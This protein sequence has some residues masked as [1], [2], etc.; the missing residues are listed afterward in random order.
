MH[1]LSTYEQEKQQYLQEI[2]KTNT[3]IER[4]L[5]NQHLQLA[6]NIQI[7]KMR[8]ILEKN[9]KFKHKLQ[10]NEFEIAIVGL[11]KAGKSTFANALIDNYV[12]PS[13][14]ERCTFTSTRLVSGDDN[15]T[16]EFYTEAEFNQIFCDMLEE[17]DYPSSQSENFRTI[18]LLKFEQYFDNLGGSNPGLYK[19]HLGKTDEEIKDILKNR[20]RLTLT[21]ATQTFSGDQLNKDEFQSY[22]KGENNDTSKPRSVKSIEI[23]SA[24]LKNMENAI[25]YD[26]PG[27][28][29]PTQLHIRQTE[30]RLKKADVI[31]LVTNVGRNP[32][33]QGTSL[34]V[35]T[36][37]TDAD[38]VELKDKLFV[39]GNQLDL[40]NNS[41][42]LERNR[43][44]LTHDVQ[45]YKIGEAKRVFVGSAYKYLVLDHSIIDD[46]EY[47][48][49]Y[50]I[51]SG[52]ED[53]RQALVGY[54]ETERFEI[55]K[56]KIDSNKTTIKK[57]FS[58][59]QESNQ[60]NL[61]FSENSEFQKGIIT[62]TESKNIEQRIKKDLK[63]F[64]HNKKREVYDKKWLS[65]SITNAITDDKFFRLIDD[66]EF[67]E[68]R[69][70][71]DES[72]RL[73]IPFEK[74][75]CAI[76]AKLYLEF[77]EQYIELIK[78]IT[79]QK[80]MDTEEELLQVF[81]TAVAGNA[82]YSEHIKSLCKKFIT[83]TTID[84]LHNDQRFTYLIERFS[85]PIFDIILEF[86]VGNSD[87]TLRFKNHQADVMMLDHYY[88]K[89]E[90]VLSNVMLVQKNTN[91][92]KSFLDHCDRTIGTDAIKK[93]SLG[94]DYKVIVDGVID[95]GMF[96]EQHIE[97]RANTKASVLKEI[98]EDISNLRMI[99][100]K[101]V[102]PAIDL[103]MSFI[104][105]L[106]KQVKI[107]LASA[108]ESNNK[109][110][111][112]FDEFV[113]GV[114]LETR[115]QD[116]DNITQTI[117]RQKERNAILEEIQNF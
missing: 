88:S 98:N 34:N 15:A 67:D 14:P 75:N 70:M 113:S 58:E 66:Q 65:Q 80:C 91:L 7:E 25:I 32:S 84:V 95:I 13:A 33:I 94:Y 60:D 99:L 5:K 72:S 81:C 16:V 78:N 63:H 61:E 109:H 26:V 87:R 93:R 64:L 39:F 97:S 101:A 59:L 2:D 12:L 4:V 77:L 76:R 82:H 37:N 35:I 40:V 50:E 62:R 17:L 96:I 57:I 3:V 1:K 44:I 56:R 114:M 107:I 47:Q 46:A 45:K 92:A 20:D 79:N 105:G 18:D 52:I 85:R 115:K 24:Q 71:A 6:T 104:N 36:K 89:N 21:G 42:D 49:R 103:E 90:G 86:P 23:K 112:L 51:S 111:H 53:I 108:T 27:F 9:Q 10:S 54:Y 30:D 41:S 117:E 11:E 28:D 19:S 8:E 73:D 74:I 83:K 55:L 116:L 106:D 48:C 100:S 69:I 38:G 110:A 102:V 29:S 68:V 43:E 31:I 22:I